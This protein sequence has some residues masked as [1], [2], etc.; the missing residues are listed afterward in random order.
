[1]IFFN[2]QTKKHRSTF[3]TG[4]SRYR[5]IILI[6]DGMFLR[7]ILTTDQFVP[8]AV[9]P[10]NVV[11]KCLCNCM[12]LLWYNFQSILIKTQTFYTAVITLKSLSAIETQ[13]C[14]VIQGVSY[15]M[16]FISGILVD[17]VLYCGQYDPGTLFSNTHT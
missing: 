1:M 4:N 12:R 9:Y 15:K 11:K 2:L 10:P 8:A 14:S 16:L 13:S 6:G 7:N 17:I 3:G 5:T